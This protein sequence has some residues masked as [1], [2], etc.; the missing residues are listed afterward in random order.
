[1]LTGCLHPVN[2]KWLVEKSYAYTNLARVLELQGQLEQSLDVY[3][4]IAAINDSLLETEP[5]NVEY[6]LE[7]GYAHN[8]IGKVVQ[9]LGRLEEAERHFKADLEIKQAISHLDPGHNQRRSY[10]ATSHQYLGRNAMARGDYNEARVAFTNAIEIVY[11]LHLLDPGS[12]EWQSRLATYNRELAAV[13]IQQARLEAARVALDESSTRWAALLQTDEKKWSWRTGEG[14]TKTYQ[15]WL[16]LLD[17]EAAQ[18]RELSSGARAVFVE[19]F[20][21]DPGNLESRKNLVLAG[22]IDGDAL[23]A[24]GAT[25]AAVAAWRESLAA[26]DNVSVIGQNPELT[27]LAAALQLRLGQDQQAQENMGLLE[28]MGYK[29]RFVVSPTG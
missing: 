16:A 25:Q 26:L 17:G 3:R 28:R 8:N 13:E 2:P 27:E 19:L 18:S 14:L 6:Q 5:E 9:S 29:T 11:L 23:A 7:V 24:N 20:E 15:S 21:Q 10:L 4:E 1:M 12:T 22:L